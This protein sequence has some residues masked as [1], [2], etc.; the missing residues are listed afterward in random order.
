VF[1]AVKHYKTG[2]LTAKK[3]GGRIV[4]GGGILGTGGHWALDSPVPFFTLWVRVGNICNFSHAF[5][6]FSPFPENI[7]WLDQNYQQRQCMKP[8][9]A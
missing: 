2:N 4:N 9:K 3:G 6:A 1:A 8:F 7:Q 5:S